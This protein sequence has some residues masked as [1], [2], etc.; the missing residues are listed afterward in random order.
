MLFAEASC[1][2]SFSSLLMALRSTLPLMLFTRCS[3]SFALS[4]IPSM[5]VVNSN[6][7]PTF[8]KVLRANLPMSVNQDPRNKSDSLTLF[9]NPRLLLQVFHVP[10]SFLLLYLKAFQF[11][12]NPRQLHITISNGVFLLRNRL[13]EIFQLLVETCKMSE[14]LRMQC[15]CSFQLYLWGMELMRRALK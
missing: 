2:S 13:V 5:S 14:F 10:Q 8:P 12:I 11:S 3:S 15:L 4:F 1:F 9:L 6:S 7:V